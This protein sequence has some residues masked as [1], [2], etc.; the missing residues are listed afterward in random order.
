MKISKQ[1]NPFDPV[2]MADVYFSKSGQTIKDGDVAVF[3]PGVTNRAGTKTNG[4]FGF[5]F[6]DGCNIDP[7]TAPRPSRPSRP[8]GR[9][10]RPGT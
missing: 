9:R 7:T 10:Y 5:S 3:I 2:K 4:N 8:D 6:G 1:P